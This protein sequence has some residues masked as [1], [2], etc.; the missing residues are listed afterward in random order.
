MPPPSPLR[1]K[2][3]HHIASVLVGIVVAGS[4]WTLAERSREQAAGHLETVE[5]ARLQMGQALLSRHMETAAQQ[6]RR[7]AELPLLS[8]FFELATTQPVS[9]DA[10]ELAAYL[11]EVLAATMQEMDGGSLLAVSSDGKVLLKEPLETPEEVPQQTVTTGA[12]LHRSSDGSSQLWWRQ[13]V[14]AYQGP[15]KSGGSL[16]LKFAAN[17]LA[18]FEQAGLVLEFSGNGTNASTTPGQGPWLIAAKRPP[19]LDVMPLRLFA[20]LAGFAVFAASIWAGR[21]ARQ[22]RQ[23]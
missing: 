23:A 17:R 20:I 6:A 10:Q 4:G 5:S 18:Q 13:P 2:R 12:F 7:L 15:D 22:D 21:I 19:A 16:Y 9:V 8:E 14:P 3:S 11:Q 1:S